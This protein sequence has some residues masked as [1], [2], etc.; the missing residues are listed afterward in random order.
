VRVRRPVTGKLLMMFSLSDK[1][2]V[3]AGECYQHVSGTPILYLK[4][5]IAVKT[6]F[7]IF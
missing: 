6:K 2:N 5:F 1:V 7:P 3:H 4:Q